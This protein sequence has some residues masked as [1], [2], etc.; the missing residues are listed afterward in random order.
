MIL[1]TDILFCWSC[2]TFLI[3]LKIVIVYVRQTFII[4]VFSTFWR[5]RF[6]CSGKRTN[7]SVLWNSIQKYMNEKESLKVN[8]RFI[9]WKYIPSQLFTSSLETLL[10]IYSSTSSW[11]TP[12]AIKL[13]SISGTESSS[14]GIGLLSSSSS[15]NSTIE[16]KCLEFFFCKISITWLHH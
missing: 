13:S 7:I 11:S 16:N 3:P 14:G 4:N 12:S 1:L 10:L 9:T 2:Y 6:W 8:I 5:Q 15:S